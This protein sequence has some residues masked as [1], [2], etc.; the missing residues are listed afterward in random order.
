MARLRMSSCED[1][2]PWGR[3]GGMGATTRRL[4]RSSV[5]VRLFKPLLRCCAS[6]S[7]TPAFYRALTRGLISGTVWGEFLCRFESVGKVGFMV[8]A[9]RGHDRVVGIVATRTSGHGTRLHKDTHDSK[10]PPSPPFPPPHPLPVHGTR[11]WMEYSYSLNTCS[12]W[13]A[14]AVGSGMNRLGS[15]IGEPAKARKDC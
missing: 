3:M 13:Y 8:T 10:T 5:F 1:L 6:S 14:S 15:L 12:R 4:R 7:G 9:L 11:G 2:I